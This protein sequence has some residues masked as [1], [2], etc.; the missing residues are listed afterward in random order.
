MGKALHAVV[1][2]EYVG[3]SLRQ[4]VGR[5]ARDVRPMVSGRDLI[6]IV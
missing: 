1:V 4:S 5:R 3:D 6:L 2:G